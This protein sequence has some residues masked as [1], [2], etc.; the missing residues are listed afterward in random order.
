MNAHVRHVFFVRDLW[1]LA[2]LC[3]REGVLAVRASAARVVRR[4]LD[5]EP[6][7]L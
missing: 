4:G 1:D 2:D 7:H 5:A 6:P 3:R